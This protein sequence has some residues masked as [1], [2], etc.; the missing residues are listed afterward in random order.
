MVKRFVGAGLVFVVGVGVGWTLL[1][2]QAGRPVGTGEA[3]ARAIQVLNRVPGS[4]AGD[5]N[6]IVA[7][8]KKIEPAV[9]NIDTIGKVRDEGLIP[10]LSKENE[11][12]G[13]GSGV[14]LT[15]DG[16]IVTN[17]HVV[18]GADRVRV[19]LQDNRWFYAKRVGT[20]AQTD[21]A[22]VRVEATGLPTAEL[23][24]SDQLQ[25]GE[26][27]IALGNPLGIGSSVSLGIV[28]AVNRKNLQIDETH[29]IDGAI[30]T[31]AAINRGNSGGA[32]ANSS[33]QLIGIN[34]AILSS[35]PGGG[36]IG[37]GFA[38]PSNTV[39]RIVRELITNGKA[40][41]LK[42]NTAWLG[43]QFTPVPE[44]VAGELKIE[45]SR[46]VQISRILPG[47]PAEKSGL[48]KEDVITAVNGNVIG[49]Q[50]EVRLIIAQHK[51]GDRIPVRVLRHSVAGERE[52]TI[53]L[54]AKPASIEFKQ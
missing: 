31:D 11:V 22:V 32:L 6:E 51:V 47:S 43:I 50:D 20:D 5:R 54:G 17:N 53:T 3:Q 37:L 2:I 34:T 45:S 7:A 13:K 29:S 48:R 12:R 44:K 1:R 14:I 19:T 42:T 36:S 18:E 38:I 52:Y 9:V 26:W 24:D 15:S 8:V 25:V 21:L 46:G 4:A 49:D 23:A 39:R 28:S 27:S 30:Q 41:P 10:F 40:T 35:G 16:Y 33:G